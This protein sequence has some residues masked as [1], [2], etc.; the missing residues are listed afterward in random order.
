ML[1]AALT[2]ITQIIG[3][4]AIA[5][6]PAAFQPGLLDQADQALIFLLARRVRLGFPGVVAAGMDS[7]H[8]GTVDGQDA[9]ASWAWMNA[10]LT[11]IP[12]QSTRRPFLECR[13][14]R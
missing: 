14:P 4:L 9:D 5:I 6:D 7:H 13:A 1:A 8:L 3:D 11:G 10:Y 12:W 2:Q